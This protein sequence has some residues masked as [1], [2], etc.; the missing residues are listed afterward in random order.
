M[1]RSP[2]REAEL[3]RLLYEL[4]LLL[5]FCSIGSIGALI[6]RI[7]FGGP[8]YFNYTKEPPKIVLV[9]I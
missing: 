6:I 1:A 8:L 3:C 5:E 4:E 2:F 7:G 9:L